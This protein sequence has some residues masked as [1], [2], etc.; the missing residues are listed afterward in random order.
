M[1]TCYDLTSVITF[2]LAARGLPSSSSP[3]RSSSTA[4]RGG[5][6]A[7]RRQVCGRCPP[8]AQK[9]HLPEV[10][11]GCAEG[12]LTAPDDAPWE[13]GGGGGIRRG[14]TLTCCSTSVH[15]AVR[16]P[17]ELW[18]PPLPQ[19]EGAPDEGVCVCVCVCVC[20]WIPSFPLPL[21]FYFMHTRTCRCFSWE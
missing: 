17:G 10:C 8:P 4:D 9:G 16:S 15:S 20:V 3:G 11:V 5:L 12:S 7:G 13:G 19:A 1:L 21:S 18:A 2:D 14:R 6:P